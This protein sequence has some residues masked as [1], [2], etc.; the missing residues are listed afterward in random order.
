[1]KKTAKY[2]VVKK[3]GTVYTNNNLICVIEEIIYEYKENKVKYDVLDEDRYVVM[4]YNNAI[5]YGTNKNCN[6]FANVR[7][8]KNNFI[9]IY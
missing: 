9:Q 3:D 1:M 5:N 8:Y 2:Q 7:V 6:N 4:D